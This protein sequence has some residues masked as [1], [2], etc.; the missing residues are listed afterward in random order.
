MSSKEKYWKPA[1]M[2]GWYDP[3][4]L[5]RTGL[6]I[7]KSSL[8]A[9]NADGRLVQPLFDS[10]KLPFDETRA[11][12]SP[13]GAGGE[14]GEA[15]PRESLT[16]DY[17]ADTGD[18]FDST[19][20]VAYWATEDVLSA[21]CA[22]DVEG[23]TRAF[24]LPR[25]EV[26]ILGG[27]E[28]YPAASADGYEDRFVVPYTMA[29]SEFSGDKPALYAIPG[30]HD[31]YDNLVSFTRL[32]I[33]KE[34]VGNFR[35]RQT[36]SYFALA[37]P[38]GWWLVAPDVQLG[39]DID[40][41]QLE[42][43]EG[44]IATLPEDAKVILCVAEP[45]WVTENEEL[46]NDS[47]WEKRSSLLRD[48][49]T[50]LHGAG[51]IRAIIA[52]DNHHYRRHSGRV[53]KSERDVHLVTA[54]GGGAFLH[55]T[56][57]WRDGSDPARR[58]RD[59]RLPPGTPHYVFKTAYPSPEVSRTLTIQA[60]EFPLTNWRFL[61]ASAALYGIV[62][63]Q[64]ILEARLVCSYVHPCADVAASMWSAPT[65]VILALLII[66][67]F[68]SFTDTSKR[69]YRL[70]AGLVHGAVHA[71]AAVGFPTIAMRLGALEFGS[72]WPMKVGATLLTL[73]LT[74]AVGAV[75]AAFVMGFYL[76][77]SLNV[78]SRHRNE[79]FSAIKE[80][81]YKSFLRLVIDASGHAHAY[82]IGIEKPPS[83]WSPPFDATHPPD[84]KRRH[85]EGSF[86]RPV[87]VDHFSLD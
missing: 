65:I 69:S 43:F 10:N 45:H 26:V 25:G 11:L 47:E 56:H 75:F 44:I 77:V 55:P 37:L 34:S 41:K 61:R 2:V 19:Y 6:Q 30:N 42:Y 35:V 15:R 23:D 67:G 24:E 84:G 8:F 76:Y 80:E 73:A 74:T 33:N 50:R 68:V 21:P 52:G 62:A 16:L 71:A 79:T 18:G 28:V 72:A 20:G 12:A 66:V 40:Y 51:R 1:E 13:A 17:I 86:P 36:R 7:A 85:P 27:D 87:I 64:M 49:E 32:F 9:E 57:G 83:A 39:S 31:W 22:P 54:G 5:V 3:V 60:L 38:A 48:L 4:Q 82:V 53:G 78:F 46:R 14:V 58:E 59:A 81:R 29:S 63:A 70:S